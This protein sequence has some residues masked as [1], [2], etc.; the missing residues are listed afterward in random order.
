M[1]NRFP[2]PVAVACQNNAVP[3]AARSQYIARGTWVV[4]FSSGYSFE[5]EDVTSGSGR[6]EASEVFNRFEEASQAGGIGA[7]RAKNTS[8]V[9][10]G[11]FG[12]A[13]IQLLDDVGAS[14]KKMKALQFSEYAVLGPEDPG[15]EE[16]IDLADTLGGTVA[17]LKKRGEKEA[18]LE[19]LLD[20]LERTGKLR[21]PV[22]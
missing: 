18:R 20:D 19:E 9:A 15:Y 1:A 8:L 4:D 16:A 12:T 14:E 3:S 21:R 5:K 13:G 7:L 2:E 11:R 22:R 6:R 10:V 17:S